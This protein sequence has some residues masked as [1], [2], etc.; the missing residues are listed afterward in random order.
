M[1]ATYNGIGTH[2]YGKKDM[3]RRQGSCHSCGRETTLVSYTTRLW[4]V[5]MFIPV[6]P[7]GRKRIIDYCSACT[8]HYA[9]DLHKW[10]TAK[11]LEISEA[12]DKYRTGPTHENAIAVHQQLLK[13]HQTAQADEFQSELLE[14]F[15]D[16]AMVQC[17]LGATLEHRGLESQAEPFFAKALELRPDLPEARVGVAMKAIRDGR[18]TEATAL[19]DFLDKPGSAQLYSLGPLEYLG[20]V[21]QKTGDHES[22][23]R[24]YE[25]LLNELPG[26]GQHN[27]F[28]KKVKTSEKALG[29]TSTILPKAKFSW[30]NFLGTERS[31]PASG[32]PVVTKRGLVIAGGVAIAIGIIMVLA[33][34]NIRSHRAVYFLNGL[35]ETENLVIDGKSKLTLRPNRWQEQTL[36]EGAHTVIVTSPIKK[37]VNFE[38]KARSYFSRWFDKPVWVVNPDRSA[39]LLY[40]EATYAENPRPPRDELLYGRES[41]FLPEVSHP[42]ETLPET[43]TVEHGSK[44][45]TLQHVEAVTSIEAFLR[46]RH[47]KRTNDALQM[48]ETRLRVVPG[49]EKLFRA[50]IEELNTE[51]DVERGRNLL[52]SGLNFRPVQIEWHRAY[53]DLTKREHR[54]EL[55]ARYDSFLEKDST[56]S[57]L[58]YLRGRLENDNAK[59]GEFYNKAIE[60]DPQNAFA[61]YALAYR[62][63]NGGDWI[64]AKPLLK[65]AVEIRPDDQSFRKMYYLSQIG[66]GDIESL[67]A[68]LRD[69]VAKNPLDFLSSLQLLELFASQSRSV[70][71][72][73]LIRTVVANARKK[74]SRDVSS[75]ESFLR[76]HFLYASGQFAELEKLCSKDSSPAGRAYLLQALLEQGKINEAEKIRSSDRTTAQD[77]LEL[78]SFGL[79]SRF[80]GD[81]AK[82]KEF[83]DLAVKG[84]QAGPDDLKA[85]SDLLA[86]EQAPTDA[87]V[88]DLRLALQSKALVAAVLRFQHPDQSARFSQLARRF[89]LEQIPPYH[90]I[91]RSALSE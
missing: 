12:L 51:K 62:F 44:E 25:R 16:Q 34:A 42:F 49:D 28:R 58:L 20:D 57:A 91:Q 46:L 88:V 90:L 52:E 67:Q 85:A 83:F 27:A 21:F 66:S 30:R 72:E 6:L 19:L 33:N 18:L 38:V 13:F 39:C 81:T 29:R 54:K 7:L 40:R 47:D 89:N 60:S 87:Q 48:A 63:W 36:A 32:G 2:Y 35:A 31:R 79:A 59:A 86:S 78:L 43:V 22:A 4:F 23:L 64:R 26:A 71:A 55:F 5:V 77:P 14:K 75:L 68:D 80:A 69:R 37:T 50:Y 76:R 10:E 9:V 53:Q 17:Y 1:P 56:N 24:I 70:D 45:K 73:S 41:Y 61:Y 84:F 74:E 82:S 3:E 15:G 8:R 65:Q 11:Q